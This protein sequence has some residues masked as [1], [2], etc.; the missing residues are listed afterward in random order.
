M[1]YRYIYG[2][3]IFNVEEMVILSLLRIRF[4]ARKFQNKPIPRGIV[5]DM[6]EAARLSPSGG[7]E[8]AWAFGVITDH[9]MI[10]KIAAISYENQLWMSAAPLLVVLCTRISEVAAVPDSRDVRFPEMTEQIRAIPNNVLNAIYMEEHQVKIP[11]TQMA[12]VALEQ[13][14]QCTWVSHFDV[15][16][17]AKLLKLPKEYLPSNILAFG[18][19]SNEHPAHREDRPKK[20]ALEQ[21]VFYNTGEDLASDTI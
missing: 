11:G 18:Y 12:L 6:L 20:K 13:G 21:I 16:K 14:I 9:E 8:Q 1:K 4:S 15:C 5:Q 7:N 10:R 3:F 17:L 2:I 19:P